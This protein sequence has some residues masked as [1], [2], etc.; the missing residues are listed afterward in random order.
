MNNFVCNTLPSSTKYDGHEE[1]KLRFGAPDSFCFKASSENGCGH[2]G[3]VALIRMRASKYTD[4]NHVPKDSF[5]M[6][7]SIELMQF[8]F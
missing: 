8:Y 5:V 7:L 3:I 2:R 4:I 6:T 1:N